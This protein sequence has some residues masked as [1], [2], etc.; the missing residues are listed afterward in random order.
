MSV[1]TAE[2]ALRE[3]LDRVEAAGEGLRS[4]DRASIADVVAE[5]WERIAD[6]ELSCGRAAR[7]RIPVSSGLS[8][9]MVA[10]ALSVTFE[11]VRAE[12]ASLAARMEPPE[13]TREA[14]ARLSALVLAGNVFTACVAPLCAGLLAKVPLV[15]KASTKDDVMPRLFVDALREV[16]AALADACLVVAIPGGTSNLEA[17][18]FARADAVSAYGTDETLRSIR[19]RLSAST[20]FVMHGHGLGLGYVSPDAELEGAAEAFA[21]DVAAY[22]Q[23]GCMSPHAIGVHKGADAHRFARHLAAAL[24]ALQTTMP[25]GPLPPEVGAAQVQWRGVAEARGLLIEGSC[26]AVSYEGDVPPRLT[27]GWRN[28]MVFETDRFAERAA[29]YGAHLKTVGVAGEPDRVARALP[30]PLS[31]RVCPAG[32]MQRPRLGALADGLPPWQGFRRLLSVET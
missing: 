13:G 5:A 10:W 22:D 20:S 23:R 2:G 26:C 15:V 7:E 31:P 6:P 3:A 28:V 32:R 4:R 29:A 30:T 17:T 19:D 21:L 11:D 8:L 24:S 1:E 25:R 9:P 16:D 12:L 14:P 27:P 18:L